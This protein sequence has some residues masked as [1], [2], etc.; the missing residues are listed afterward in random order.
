[1]L[2]CYMYELYYHPNTAS[3]ATH[4]VLLELHQFW[5]VQ[6]KLHLVDF[7]QKEQK[8]PSYLSLNPKGRVPTLIVDGKAYTEQSAILLLLS[9]IH[10]AAGLAPAPGS[11]DRARF[12]EI[13]MFIANSL[14]PALRDWVYASTDGDEKG[15]EAVRALAGKRIKES[16]AYLDGILDGRQYLVGNKP[17]IADYMAAAT[18]SWTKW[19]EKTAMGYENVSKWAERMKSRESWGEVVKR[20]PGWV[21]REPE[22][23]KEL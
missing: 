10:E 14:L 4:W 19:V 22:F 16:W 11:A 21:V 15:A 17:S 23:E 1:M 13:Y 2:F 5:A 3:L 18:V 7:A 9:E 12:L 8:S 6:Y 20:E